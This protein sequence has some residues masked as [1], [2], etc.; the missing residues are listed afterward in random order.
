MS[1]QR[2][3]Q[4]QVSSASNDQRYYVLS[5]IRNYEN[6]LKVLC[7]SCLHGFLALPFNCDVTMIRADN[8]SA[9]F[10][11]IF[12]HVIQM[13]LSL[14]LLLTLEGDYQNYIFVTLNSLTKWKCRD[15]RMRHADTFRRINITS[16]TRAS[17]KIHRHIY[18]MLL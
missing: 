17:Y 2:G 14:T 6:I 1:K 5:R 4:F 15:V 7:F 8:S 11:R 18:F 3:L 13:V 16:T 12:E 10:F 9:I